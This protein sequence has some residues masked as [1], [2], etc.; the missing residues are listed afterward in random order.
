MDMRG[1]LRGG[2]ICLVTAE[3]QGEGV[4][5]KVRT[6]SGPDRSRQDQ[7]RSYVDPD[8]ALAAVSAFLHSFTDAVDDPKHRP[9]R[10]LG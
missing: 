6:S 8:E 1:D 10:E 3:V 9:H 7:E 4:L 5:I 2:V